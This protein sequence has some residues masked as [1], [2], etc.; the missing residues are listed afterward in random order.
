MASLK[1]CA[2]SGFSVHSHGA[3]L[4]MYSCSGNTRQAATFGASPAVFS[5]RCTLN[6]AQGFKS[7]VLRGGE[8]PPLGPCVSR[9]IVTADRTASRLVFLCAET[10]SKPASLRALHACLAF[11]WRS[12]VSSSAV[13][14]GSASRSGRCLDP[15]SLEDLSAEQTELKASLAQ[16]CRRARARPLLRLGMWREGAS[17]MRRLASV[18]RWACRASSGSSPCSAPSLPLFAF[19]RR[20]VQFP[21][22][23]A[24]ATPA[25][26]CVL[27]LA[28][29]D[30]SAF[31]RAC[32]SMSRAVQQHSRAE[33]NAP[34]PSRVKLATSSEAHPSLPPRR[35]SFHHRCTCFGSRRMCMAHAPRAPGCVGPSSM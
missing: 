26:T 29:R 2:C 4:K 28:G 35:W 14:A 18:D 6:G 25:N 5:S 10:C 22:A 8:V 32:R 11:R 1:S 19:A 16:V 9:C 12:G 34:R 24:S 7:L 13:G 33:R 31:M 3:V 20:S 15:A 27:R 30:Q 21:S 17:L 23:V